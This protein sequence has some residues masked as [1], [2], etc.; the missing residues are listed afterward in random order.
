MQ[1]KFYWTAVWNNQP[2]AGDALFDHDD[3][4]DDDDDDGHGDGGDDDVRINDVVADK[5]DGI[6]STGRG[7]GCTSLYIL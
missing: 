1:T 2:A 7:E 6:V 5:E 4:N 3:D